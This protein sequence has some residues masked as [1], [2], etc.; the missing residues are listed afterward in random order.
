MGRADKVGHEGNRMVQVTGINN[1]PKTWPWA[2]FGK[3]LVLDMKAT[4]S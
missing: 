2:S 3:W 1:L 4:S